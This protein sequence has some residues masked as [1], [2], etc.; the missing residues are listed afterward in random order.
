VRARPTEDS[1]SAD[2]GEQLA[3]AYYQCVSRAFARAAS[4]AGGTTEQHLQIGESGIRLRFAGQGMAPVVLPALSHL[5]GWRGERPAINVDLWD[6]RTTGVGVP[7]PPWRLRD[8]V[9]RGD[10][11]SLSGGRIRAQ[12]DT[13]NE[14]LTLWDSRTRHGVMWVADAGRLP[15]WVHASPLRSVLHW[16][17]AGAGR[18]LVHA[19][20]VGDERRGALLVG[21][22]G[23]GKSTTS[24]ACLQDG[25]GFVGDD[26]VVAETHGSP[27]AIGVYGTARLSPDSLR[28]LPDLIASERD[29]QAAKVVVDIARTRPELTRMS[30]AISVILLPRVTP[31]SLT[32]RRV[33]AA[34]ALRALAPS[35]ILQHPDESAGGLA[36]SSA[37]VRSVPAFV[38]ELGADIS[39]VAPAI[40]ALLERSA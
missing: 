2:S 14:I 11:R 29:W 6:E 34:E 1:R 5:T 19:A 16:G 21:P 37:L 23:S 4:V 15:Y 26:Y 22:G 35:T 18:H 36:V 13:G 3:A 25:L 30:A 7:P 28:L 39:E 12:V 38:L 32:L 9:A 20:A 31:G 17:L 8:V 10:V 40:R 33:G 27:R 24:V